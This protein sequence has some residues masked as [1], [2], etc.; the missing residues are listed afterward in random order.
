MFESFEIFEKKIHKSK[1]DLQI[2]NE[3]ANLN[4]INNL[5][6][7]AFNIVKNKEGIDLLDKLDLFIKKNKNISKDL[8]N[9]I[10]IVIE[11]IIKI[12]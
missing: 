9:D 4:E 5:L 2:I 3:N 1:N 8:V 10:K 7:K 11:E 6:K 12:K